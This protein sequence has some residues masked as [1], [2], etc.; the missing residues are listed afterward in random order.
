MLLALGNKDLNELNKIN[1]DILKVSKKFTTVEIAN[2]VMTKFKPEKNFLNSVSKY[3]AT[4]GTLKSAS[5]V[6][7]WCSIKTR[8]KIREIIKDIDPLTKMILLNAI[9]FKGEWLEEFNE[10][11]TIKKPFYNLNDQSKVVQI[12]KMIKTD[13]SNYY[14]DNEIQMVELPYKKDSM[15]AIILLP[16]EKININNYI[17]NLNDEK[18]QQTFKRM[19]NVKVHLELPKFELEFSSSLK[20]TLQKLGMLQPFNKSTADFSEMKKEKDIY[21]DEV[22]QKTYL[23]VDEKGT[24]A[25]AVSEVNSCVFSFREEKIEKII[26]NRPFLFLLRNEKLPKNYEMMFMAKIETL[27]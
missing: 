26:I 16:K 22:I 10:K 11:D 25:A 5:Q 20:S 23:K 21:I 24:E 3:E 13:Y 12:D 2:A 19:R 8:G 18:L 15:S 14:Y 1:L 6:N 4:V 27:K 7:K 9:Y 17:S